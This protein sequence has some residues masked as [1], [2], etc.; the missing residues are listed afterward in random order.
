MS[1]KYS[2]LHCKVTREPTCS[3]ENGGFIKNVTEK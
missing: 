1:L 3:F 2:P